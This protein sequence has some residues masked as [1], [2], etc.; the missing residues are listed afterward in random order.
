[1]EQCISLSQIK[2]VEADCVM[3][4]QDIVHLLL[5]VIGGEGQADGFF[6]KFSFLRS[7]FGGMDIIVGDH[8]VYFGL[9]SL[10]VQSLLFSR[11]TTK[12]LHPNSS[13]CGSQ[14]WIGIKAWPCSLGLHP[15][16]MIG[17][18]GQVWLVPGG[19]VDQAFFLGSG[20]ALSCSD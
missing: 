1:M 12:L 13:L 14:F 2:L 3:V 19:S 11:T 17:A 6:Y 20:Q 9:I 16:L 5:P 10:A 4:L 15:N 18:P 8:S 7:E